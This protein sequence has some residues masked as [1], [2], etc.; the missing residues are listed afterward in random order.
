[1]SKVDDAA[2][3][4]KREEENAAADTMFWREH[5]LAGEW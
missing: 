4:G 3:A 5:L 2:T 1:M